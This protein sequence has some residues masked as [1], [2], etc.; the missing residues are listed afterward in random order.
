MD[1][2]ALFAYCFRRFGYPNCGWDDYKELTAYHL[3]TP[4]PDMILMVVPYIRGQT[5]LQLRFMV[6]EDV[7]RA[8]DA[9]ARREQVAWRARAVERLEEAGLPEWMEE[10]RQYCNTPGVGIVEMGGESAHWADTIPWMTL[11]AVGDPGS[12]AYLQS[13][14]ADAFYKSWMAEAK[15]AEPEPGYTDRDADWTKWNE[16]DPLK[17]LAEAACVALKDLSRPVGVRDLAINAFG[18]CEFEEYAAERAAVSGYPSGALGNVAPEAFGE[19]HGMILQLG[20]GDAVR[21]IDKAKELLLQAAP[22][23]RQQ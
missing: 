20:Q 13:S 14:R 16:D 1:Y 9:Y 15:A 21:G 22:E 4:H 11:G 19:L 17:P 18:E 5:H 23:I 2:G 12:E 6:T 8:V 3:T 7:S 10:W